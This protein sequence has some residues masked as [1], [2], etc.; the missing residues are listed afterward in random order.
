MRLMYQ[1]DTEAI[2]EKEGR[3]VVFKK[4]RGRMATLPTSTLPR[5]GITSTLYSPVLLVYTMWKFS[6]IEQ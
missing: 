2:K 1:Q 6:D 4:V 3:G 5:T